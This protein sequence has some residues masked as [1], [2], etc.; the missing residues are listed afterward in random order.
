MEVW[1]RYAGGPNDTKNLLKP[2]WWARLLSGWL[3]LDAK[4]GFRSDFF[5]ICEIPWDI[6]VLGLFFFSFPTFVAVLFLG[7]SESNWCLTSEVAKHL[8]LFIFGTLRY[9]T[10]CFCDCGVQ[11]SVDWTPFEYM[12]PGH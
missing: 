5:P 1:F 9:F 10:G 6:R 4:F 2:I 11:G 12:L 7:F 8:F 3:E